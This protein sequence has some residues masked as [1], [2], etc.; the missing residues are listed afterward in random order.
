M[1][2]CL[3]I[4]FLLLSGCANFKKNKINYRQA[5]VEIEE[6]NNHKAILILEEYLKINFDPQAAALQA[7]LLFGESNYLE[8]VQIL[9]KALRYTKNSNLKYDILNN[10]ACG[11]MILEKDQDATAIWH[12]ISK[13]KL[14]ATPELAY[15]NLG[16]HEFR[17][18]NYQ[19]ASQYFT[20]CLA[21][22]PQYYDA[23]WY[24][25]LTYAYLKDYQL[26]REQLI[27]LER[28]LPENT[29]VLNLQNQ[30]NKLCQ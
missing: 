28:Q 10:L 11:L 2:R 21:L 13:E 8:G 15:F 24:L 9:Q 30:I 26:A 12:Q 19:A 16:F 20:Q 27:I 5:L 14:Y 18:Q 23:R 25:S 29:N 6:G 22:Q 7:N 3:I 4:T 17:S 1:N